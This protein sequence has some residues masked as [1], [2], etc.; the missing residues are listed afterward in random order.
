MSDPQRPKKMEITAKSIREARKELLDE[1]SASH[2]S[3]D[4]ES[5]IVR[6]QNQDVPEFLNSLD[7]FE[8]ASSEVELEVG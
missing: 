6:F 2:S 3:S 7:A 8:Q 4:P 5:A 1:I